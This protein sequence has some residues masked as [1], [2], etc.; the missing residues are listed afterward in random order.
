MEVL[1][2]TPNLINHIHYV[3]LVIDVIY[4]GKDSSTSSCGGG[5]GGRSVQIGEV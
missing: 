5:S 2:K 1:S 4:T 3:N